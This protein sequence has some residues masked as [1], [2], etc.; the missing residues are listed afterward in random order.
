[1]AACREYLLSCLLDNVFEESDFAI[2]KC[3]PIACVSQV[4]VI[5]F[6]YFSSYR[7]DRHL[8]PV[9]SRADE[10]GPIFFVFARF[11]GS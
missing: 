6:Q 1:V 11:G 10:V 7:L 4:L 9:P 8:H 2:E 5:K 3:S